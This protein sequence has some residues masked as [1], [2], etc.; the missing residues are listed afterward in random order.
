[1]RWRGETIDQYEDRA[2]DGVS[3]FALFP[4][5]MHDGT[6]VWLERYW[7]GLRKGVNNRR[8]WLR[9]LNKEDCVYRAP[10]RPPPPKK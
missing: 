8:W 7:A 4:T 9:S 10:Q 5:Q 6:W 1:M 2:Q 3:V